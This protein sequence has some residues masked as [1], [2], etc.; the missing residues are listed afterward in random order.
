MTHD[1]TQPGRDLELGAALRAA[2]GP[3]ARSDSFVA[4]VLAGYHTPPRV[5]DALASW[6]RWGV[7]AAAVAL[8][9]AL[10]AAPPIA[11]SVASLDD[12][13]TETYPEP[14]ATLMSDDASPA[15]AILFA[16]ARG[17]R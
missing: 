16:P 12:A 8:I 10:L 11:D 7:A 5:R 13:L 9:A 6:S 1:P 4:A 3:D 14:L 2:L 15:S 17:G